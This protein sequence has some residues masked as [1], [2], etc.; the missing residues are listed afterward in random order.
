VL[1]AILEEEIANQDMTDIKLL[2]SLFGDRL[3]QGIQLAN[4]TAARIGGPVD[5]LLTAESADDLAHLVESLWERE[6][7][8]VILGGG[9]NILVSDAGVRGVVILNRARQVKFNVNGDSASVWAESGANLGSVARQAAGR[10]LSGLEWAVGIPGTIG[11]AIVGNAGAHGSE[12]ADNLLMAEIL[13]LVKGIESRYFREYWEREA[14]TFE[15]RSS[16]IKRDPG[17]MVVLSAKLQLQ[18]STHAAVQEK[19]SEFTA[20]R[21]RTQP[22][23][24][25]MGSMFKNPPGDYAGRLIEAAGLKGTRI[26]EAEISSLH[27]NFFVNRGNARASDVRNL[28][29][30]A[31]NRVKEEFNIELELEIELI[32]DW[33]LEDR[34][35]E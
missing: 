18:P 10:G 17:N 21:Q 4:F 25:S 27:A 2:R 14:L 29:D 13:H 33:D 34:V 26:G 8:F 6:V 5:G 32:G 11:G 23:G 3:K 7:D 15:Y 16:K 31:R 19:T 24:A 12:T 9:S 28:I 1:N 22:P 30:L 20:Y 35:E